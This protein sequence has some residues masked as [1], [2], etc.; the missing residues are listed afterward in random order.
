MAKLRRFKEMKG[1][2]Y[3]KNENSLP[4]TVLKTP[5]MRI[6]KAIDM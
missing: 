5:K 4:L 1:V 6:L 3:S 2:K